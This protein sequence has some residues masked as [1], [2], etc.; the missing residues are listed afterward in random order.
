[1]AISGVSA[2]SMM[3]AYMP[4]VPQQLQPSVPQ[5]A[6]TSDI[7]NISNQARQLASDGD[8]T[9]REANETLAVKGSE[10]LKGLL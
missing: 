7:V 6:S 2:S 9:A 5:K 8:T 4:P 1:M 10:L 3:S